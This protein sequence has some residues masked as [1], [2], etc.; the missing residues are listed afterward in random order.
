M[1]SLSMFQILPSHVVKAI[2]DHVASSTR[3]AYDGVDSY[4]QEWLRLQVPL[5]W[6]CHNLRAVV[7]SQLSRGCR[8]DVCS[9]VNS[10]R[11]PRPLHPESLEELEPPVRRL[12]K[13]IELVVCEAEIYNG[14][15]LEQIL[16]EEYRDLQLPLAQRIQIIFTGNGKYNDK[17]EINV[18][19]AESNVSAFLQRIRQLAPKLTEIDLSAPFST[20]RAYQ[21]LDQHYGGLVKRLLQLTR[22]VTFSEN[23]RCMTNMLQLDGIRDLVHLRYGIYGDSEKFVQLTRRCALTLQSLD[24]GSPNAMDISGIVRDAEGNYTVYPRLLT[25]KLNLYVRWYSR[26]PCAFAGAVPFPNLRHISII[27]IYPFDDDI[28]FRG[29]AAT[30][31]SLQ[32]ELSGALVG[33]IKQYSVFACDSHPKLR[34]VDYWI[35]KFELLPRHF[36][37]WATVAQFLLSMTSRATVI[38]IR[39]D[40]INIAYSPSFLLLCNYTHIQRLYLQYVVPS[41][42]DVIALSKSLPLLS[43]LQTCTS[44]LAPLPVGVTD[45]KLLE[46]V[47]SNYYPMG[48]R[49]R[50]WHIAFYEE[51]NFKEIA[52]CVLL[53]ALVCPNFTYAAVDKYHRKEFMATMKASIESPEFIRH[54]PRLRCLLFSQE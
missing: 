39:G 15:T 37:D 13:E 1:T 33:V 44:H 29:S 43:D 38:Q 34:Y 41:L 28:L 26:Q 8:I 14:D 3:L 42:W 47:L 2:V 40:P 52:R 19:K 54:A 53:L 7:R 35:S 31:E 10:Q 6:I 46:H 49:F 4:S 9:S 18:D 17:D 21:R 51:Y 20:G 36:T 27:R 50:C 16:R 12:V 25:L 48:Q 22:H 23:E 45:E 11:L 5:L 32:V 30:L 24:I